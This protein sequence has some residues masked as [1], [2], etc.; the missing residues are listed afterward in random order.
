VATVGA[1]GT[2]T[3]FAPPP[4]LPGAQAPER[5]PERSAYPGEPDPEAGETVQESVEDLVEQFGL[6][7]ADRDHDPRS[8]TSLL[9]QM[10]R[11]LRYRGPSL[12]SADLAR[13]AREPGPEPRRAL[14]WH[15]H[16]RHFL[17][18]RPLPPD[19]QHGPLRW[20][21]D[22][23]SWS[24]HVE[25]DPR[26]STAEVPHHLASALAVETSLRPIPLAGRY[27]ALAAY[28]EFLEQLPRR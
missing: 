21:L 24:F 25:P 13:L 3:G 17:A 2:R 28:A 4:D 6:G 26:L 9:I 12:S 27:P 11:G 19:F 20:Q 22:V 10:D 5:G 8:L 18:D 23:L 14:A 15:A 16:I 7:A 1:R